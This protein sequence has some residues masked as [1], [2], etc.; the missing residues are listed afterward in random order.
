[1]TQAIMLHE[2]KYHTGTDRI[3]LQYFLL[4]DQ[5]SFGC[6]TL[7]IYGVR[8][9]MFCNGTPCQSRTMRGLTPF[10]HKV[11]AIL[12]CLSDGLVPPEQ[13]G[14]FV[15]DML[16]REIREKTGQKTARLL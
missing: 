8:A 16:S 9:S 3:V 6:N 14:R 11:A 1:M 13:M 15:S 7:D 4:V 5:I 2:R 12:G 10:S